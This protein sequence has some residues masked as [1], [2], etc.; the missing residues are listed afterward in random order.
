VVL[1]SGLLVCVC[2]DEWF[3]AVRVGQVVV[4]SNTMDVDGSDPMLLGAAESFRAGGEHH[5]RLVGPKGTL[6]YGVCT[7]KGRR[8]TQEDAHT[9]LLFDNGASG[10]TRV[11]SLADQLAE[12]GGHVDEVQRPQSSPSLPV[13]LTT[14]FDFCGVFDGHGG[15]RAAE[16]ASTQVP[17]LL[18]TYAA[19]PLADA[20]RQA[21]LDTEAEFLLRAKD[22]QLLDGTT[23]CVAVVKGGV[24]VH[25]NVGDSELVLCRR[26][27]KRSDEVDADVDSGILA[28]GLSEVHNPQ[29]NPAEAD[30][31]RAVGGKLW[32]HRLCHPVLA[33]QFCS[34]AVSRSIGD[35]LF[36]H[37]EFTHGKAAALVGTPFVTERVLDTDDLF[38]LLACDGIWDV[39]SHHQACSV[40]MQCLV[41][42]NNPQKAADEVVQEAYTK[43]S[44]DNITALV[45]CFVRIQ[46]C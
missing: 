13:L 20:L 19:L 40:V 5:L 9:A 30:R 29:R 17:A 43:G 10:L 6:R 21:L 27:G 46:I 35:L 11:A 24:L 42:T 37:E 31:V 14:D 4:P 2:V 22:Q 12:L 25:G 34:I 39:L 44:T 8:S 26:S 45:L 41:T 1:L 23:A 36:K 33:P 32:A 7:I 18:R 15:P 28:V 16:F 38:V 3:C